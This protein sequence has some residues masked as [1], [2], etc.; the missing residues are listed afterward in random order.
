MKLIVDLLLD[1]IKK[2]NPGMTEAQLRTRRFGLESL[3]YELSKTII[4]I[5]LFSILGHTAPYLVSF[6]VYGSIRSFSGGYHANS[7]WSCFFVSLIGFIFTIGSGLYLEISNIA[8][9]ILLVVSALIDLVLAP[10]PHPNKPNMDP[11]KRK[12][13]KLISFIVMLVFGGIAFILPYQY[14]ITVVASILLAAIM[15]PLGLW[16]NK[17]KT[18][19]KNVEVQND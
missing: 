18:I 14:K 12:R 4:Y 5:I 2:Y 8:C 7:Y 19:H 9:V 1:N 15:Q 13:F 11:V 6:L 17:T 3:L 16:L 10:V